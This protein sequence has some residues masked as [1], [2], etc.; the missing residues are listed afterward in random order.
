MGVVVETHHTDGVTVAARMDRL[1][2]TRTH[3]LAT[4]AIGFGLFFDIY[5]I[6][7]AGVLGTVLQEDI[8][9][10]KTALALLLSSAFIG[11]FLGSLTLGRLADRL[12]RRRAFLLTLGVYSVF[13]LLAAFSVG[14]VMLVICRFLAGLGIGAEPPISD[15]Y[16]GDL[17]PPK[18]R[19]RYIAWA[20]TLSFVGVPVAGFL[21]HWLVPIT[22]LNIAGWR[23]MFVI[24]AV[25]AVIVLALRTGLPES[26]RWLEAVGRHRDAEAVVTRF[27]QEAQAEGTELPEPDAETAVLVKSGRLRDLVVPPYLRRTLMMTLFHLLQPLGYYGFGTL[28]PLILVAK[29]FPIVQ[30]LLFSAVTFIGYPVGSALSLP[31]VERM[32]RKHLII[33]SALAM[34]GFGF[35]FGMS[36]ATWAIVLFGFIYTAISNLFSNAFHIYQAEIFPTALRA[37]AT[38]ST[39]SL[40]RL[41][42]A[43]MPF[44][45]LPL[46][47][48]GGPGMLFTVVGVAMAVVAVNV[49]VLGP[50]T[51]GRRLENVNANSVTE[52]TPAS[53]NLEAKS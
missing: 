24:G 7:L 33:A 53:A 1:P 49:G 50:S 20:Y 25:G 47:Q 31:I 2:I 32:E 5:E 26:P 18:R 43:V 35:A 29:G 51:T 17:L 9:L 27:E 52:P 6:F 28:V 36:T 13:S 37:T 41:T 44:A 10:G 38:S 14:P 11:M 16:L 45:L 21:A 39:Y 8:H 23:W 48:N 34:A 42:S 19:G 4:V 30:S 12:G 22:L 40:S 46:L 3:R 15:T